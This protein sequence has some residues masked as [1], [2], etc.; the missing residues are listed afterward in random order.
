M[1]D[2]DSVAPFLE[3]HHTAVAE[4]AQAFAKQVLAPMG[5]PKDDHDARH[6]ARS[7]VHALGEAGL[8]KHAHPLDLRACCLVREALAFQS[9][10]ADD[11][12]ALQCLGS[13][14]IASAG[15]QKQK[16]EYVAGAVSGQLMA[17][18]AMTEPDAGSDVA[19]LGTRAKKTR[20]GW[21]LHGHKTLISNAGIADFY[22]VFASTDPEAG[23][24]GIS[25][26]VVPKD[27]PGLLF[28]KAQILSNPHP[29]GELF[30]DDVEVPED[31]MVGERGGGFKL[32]MATLDS[33]RTTVAA[34][35]AGMATRALEEATAWSL[36]RKQFGAPIADLQLIQAKLARMV[37]ELSASRLLIYRAAHEK[38]TQGGRV[39]LP[40]AMAKLHATES[41]Q[42]IIDDAVQIFGGRGVLAESVVDQLYRAIRPLRIYEG[43]SEVQ[44]LVIA[45]GWL[46]AFQSRAR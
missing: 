37:T 39:S 30:F 1:I 34:A 25:C 43:T 38:D 24:R 44:H 22:S 28:E 3:P 11:I 8:V 15:N 19:S 9:P 36:S 41:A 6:Q 5:H 16:D 27:A 13:T 17:G 20:S 2:L 40:C 12:Y 7:I 4:A 32:G 46:K 14:P 10:L 35:A 31:A 45:R 18:F 33:L 26:F 29:L 42:R 21:K 23:H